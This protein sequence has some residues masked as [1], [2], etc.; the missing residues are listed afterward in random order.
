[1]KYVALLLA[2]VLSAADGPIGIQIRVLEGEGETYA[3]GS[4]A[5][6][7][8]KV[9]VTDEAGK[10]VTAAS[11]NFLLPQEGPSGTFE[12][13]GRSSLVTTD[14]EGNAAI[15]GMQWNSTPGNFDIRVVASKGQVRAGTIVRQ[16]LSAEMEL[17]QQP[18][19][20]G[21]EGTFKASH[22]H[23]KTWLILGIVAGGAAG[24]AMYARSAAKTTATSP[25]PVVPV[26][27]GGPTVIVGHP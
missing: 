11:V 21:G 16:C 6:H 18:I 25:P 23:T 15:W 7:G 5:E 22:H 27:I 9:Q 13:G 14:A 24:G 2:G 4:R 12:A 8:I 17:R 1:M 26:Q 3:V 10:A 19:A 20:S